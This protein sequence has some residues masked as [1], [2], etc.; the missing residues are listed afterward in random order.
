MIHLGLSPRLV[1]ERLGHSTIATTMDIYGH[2]F[3]EAEREAARLLDQMFD[4]A[5]SWSG[6]QRGVRAAA[7]G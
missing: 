7:A 1:M 3:P 4:A 5:V 6:V 2:I